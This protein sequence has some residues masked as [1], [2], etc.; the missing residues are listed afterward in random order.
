MPESSVLIV[1]RHPLLAE[2]VRHV[3]EQSGIQEIYEVREIA[4]ASPVVREKRPGTIIVDV[5]RGV[6][7][8]SVAAE[9]ISQHGAD[10]QVIC[11]SLDTS[12]ITVFSRHHIPR[13]GQSEL[14]A[15]LRGSLDSAL[16]ELS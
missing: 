7:C 16:K 1:S 13:A 9:L 2:A 11:I 6:S 10:C 12:D 3:V 15:L 5:E 8:A 4:E 14:V